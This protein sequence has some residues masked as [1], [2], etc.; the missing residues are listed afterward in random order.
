MTY[1]PYNTL[2]ASGVQDQ[3]VNN[4]GSLILKATPLII[5]SSG[6][7]DTVDVSVEAEALSIVGLAESDIPNSVTGSFIGSGKLIDITTTAA[8][9]D[10]LYVSKTGALT[11]VKPS[12]GVGG[13]TTGDFVISIGV[14]AKNIDNPSLKDLVLNIQVIG[15]L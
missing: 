13:F 6:E 15:Q 10:V 14:V 5:N 3:R 2:T 7:L 12:T 8:L 1:R 4:T 11:N 9:G